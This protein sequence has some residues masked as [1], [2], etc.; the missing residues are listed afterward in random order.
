MSPHD[1][2]HERARVR[3]SGGVDVVDGFAD[4]VQ[5]SRRTDREIGHGHVVIYR[6]YEPHDPEVTMALNLFIRDAI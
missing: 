6:P 5:R 1:F 3:D 2:E 4:S